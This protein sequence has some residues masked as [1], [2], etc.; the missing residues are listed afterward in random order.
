MMIRSSAMMA[1]RHFGAVR[2]LSSSSKRPPVSPLEADAGG[3]ATH[4]HHHMTTFLMVATPVY[5]FVP[6]GE[7]VDKLFG[8]ALAVV[9]SAHTWIGLNYVAADYVPKI[10]RSLLG[11]ARIVNAAIGVTTLMGLGAIA[12]NDKGGI[13]GCVA[14]LWTKPKAKK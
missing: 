13:K 9:I 6:A 8:A 11:P 2:C 1:R 10:S 3:L 7:I 14:G 12:L 5:L 4:A